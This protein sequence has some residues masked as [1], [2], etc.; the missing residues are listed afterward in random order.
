MCH[1]NTKTLRITKSN[2]QKNKFCG[3]WC[4]SAFVAKNENGSLHFL[5]YYYLFLLFAFMLP[6]YQPAVPLVAILIV[7]NWLA[8]G[9]FKQKFRQCLNDK[10][11]RV[12][13]L[14]ALL[15]MVYFIS[16][17]Y[18]DNLRQGIFELEVHLSL[19][20]FPLIFATIDSETFAGEKTRHIF[21]AFC[22]GCFLASMA[23][24]A[25]ASERYFKSS[26]LDEF[27]YTHLTSGKHP[28]YISMYFSLSVAILADILIRKWQSSSITLKS[29]LILLISWFTFIVLL[30]SSK[31]GVI[32]LIIVF[33][34]LILYS[35]RRSGHARP[36]I[37]LGLIAVL[38][39]ISAFWL[40]LPTMARFGEAF[41][42]I[43]QFRHIESA[44]TESTAERI[45]IWG[46]ALEAGAERPLTGYGIGDVREKLSLIYQKNSMQQA[47][48]LN[49]NAH[50][51]YLQTFLATGLAGIII[52]LLSL[53]LPFIT[54][55]RA[56]DILYIVFLLIIGSNFL[57]ESILCRQAGVAFYAFF[58]AYFLFSYEANDFH[59]MKP[60]YVF[61]RKYP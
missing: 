4:F 37:I 57:F 61:L 40:F 41:R 22:A 60:F 18:S 32:A 48:R 14:F 50:N 23:M 44:N 30:L 43:H 59:A 42:T 29:G 54:S 5:L 55:L 56:K 36:G 10:K 28:T 16:L 21:L 31:A 53:L 38:F 52:L 58:N 19:L 39:I 45:L 46:C 15:Y 26:D 6:I 7:L 47:S 27:I 1:Q 34:V 49:L 12:I 8:E 24:I 25:G 35:F 13:L 3:F 11:S 33:P 51:Q 17:L 2:R 9:K 20:V